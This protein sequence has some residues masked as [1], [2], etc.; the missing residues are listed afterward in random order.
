VNFIENFDWRI[1]GI[2][3]ALAF[4]GKIIGATLGGMLGGIKFRNAVAVGFGLNARG[5]MEII[6][7]T[8]A[9]NAGLISSEIF[10]ALV[11]MAL[12]TSIASAPLIRICYSPEKV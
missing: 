6:L 12:I 7:G 4:L 9:L 11:V 1:T 8:L 10:V 3:L 2:I 5:A